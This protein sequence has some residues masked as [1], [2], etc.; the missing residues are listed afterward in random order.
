MDKFSCKL[1]NSSCSQPDRDLPQ[2]LSELQEEKTAI[3]EKSGVAILV[4]HPVS[5]E[6]IEANSRASIMTGYPISDLRGMSV[7]RLL[8]EQEISLRVLEFSSLKGNGR[9]RTILRR[10]DGTLIYVDMNACTIHRG[11]QSL[12]LVFLVDSDRRKCRR[13]LFVSRCSERDSEDDVEPIYEFPNIIGK[14]KTIRKICQRI[15]QVAKTD[16]TVLIQG[17]SGTGKEVVAQAIH[18]HSHRSQGPF[19]KVNCG[20]LSETLLESELFGHVKGAFT[21]AIRDRRGRFLQA[22][23][24]TIFLDEISCM[25]LSGQAKL[26][27]VLEER[28]FEPVGSSVTT[29][30]DVRVMAAS[31]ANLKKAVSE[32]KFREDLYYRLNVFCMSLSPL[33]ARKEDIPLLAQHFLR[34]SNLAVGKEI[35]DLL[36]E[37]LALMMQ[38]DWPGNVRELENAVEH[39][40]IVAKGAVILPSDLPSNLSMSGM[41]E[42]TPDFSAEISLRAKLNLLE[43]Q[44]IQDALTRA[45]GVKKQAAALLQIDPRN[46]PHLLRKHNFL[47]SLESKEKV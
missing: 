46:F 41:L 20:A 25:S 38:Y 23:G 43:R 37:T 32:G 9:S 4:V 45:K 6:I 2:R 17:Q 29:S 40:V 8:S 44:I 26:L 7:E 21:G 15:G 12:R 33:C 47:R 39:A 11:R 10:Q 27:R 34:K 13:Q 22:D 19:V 14:S 28:E 3:F 24:G 1:R 36:P 5:G 31:N 42:E 16:S 35:R 30:V 18:C